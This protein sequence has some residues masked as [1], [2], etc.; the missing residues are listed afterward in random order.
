MI[1]SRKVMHNYSLIP[2]LLIMWIS[3]SLSDVIPEQGTHEVLSEPTDNWF[4][5]VSANG[6]YLFDS[7]NG[8]ML[9]ML[10]PTRGSI[11]VNQSRGEVY[12]PESFYARKYRG[13]RED[14]I[15]V[16]D[17]KTLLPLEEID[18]PDKI[19]SVFGVPVIKLLNNKKHLV[20]YNQVPAQSL[21]IVD[22]EN[23]K[24]VAEI[25]TPGCA[26]MLPVQNSDFL[27]ICMDGTLQMMQLDDDGQELNRVRSQNFFSVENDAVFDRVAKTKKGWL[28]ISHSGLAYNVSVDES[29][30]IIGEPWPLLTDQDLEEQW[31]PGGGSFVTTHRELNLAYIL[32]HQGGVDTHHEPGS[33]IWVFDLNKQKR[34][35]RYSSEKISS[36]EQNAKD[37][38][39]K[40]LSGDLQKGWNNILVLR[41]ENPKLIASTESGVL[42]VYDALEMKLERTIEEFGPQGL[43]F[44]F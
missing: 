29:R 28:L 24:F 3:S 4:M 23:R 43:L 39:M 31:R 38:G 41:G 1:W 9:G 15:I 44:R 12:T 6:S 10:A 13:K 42:Q 5:N 40:N 18:V 2:L 27:M 21:S 14:V 11:A 36:V 8:E 30:I 19:A 25:S 35:K 17:M 16:H 34:I 37:I 26:M 7:S 22:I 33:E 20:V 32:M